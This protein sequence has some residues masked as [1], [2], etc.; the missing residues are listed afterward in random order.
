MTGYK[1]EES[2]IQEIIDL[3]SEYGNV[4]ETAKIFCSNKELE[5]TDSSRRRIS[6]L[7][8]RKGITKSLEEIKEVDNRLDKD[9]M[10]AKK[11]VLNQS[12]FYIV[13]WEQNSTPLHKNL[14][15]NILKYAE[16][17]NAEISV[18][19]GRYKNP[20]SVFSAG[21]Y[22]TWNEETRPYWDANRHE[23][24]KFLT[25]LSDVKIQPTATNPLTGLESTT[26]S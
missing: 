17:L 11:R 25:V 18:I 4:T 12:K 19:L 22:E 14:W 9:Y 26:I 8:S 15:N 21:E 2:D 16:F 7:L 24:H 5:Y 3:Y 1:F 10:E 6:N 20:T 23:I 13:T